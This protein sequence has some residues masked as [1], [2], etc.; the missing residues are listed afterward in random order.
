M[1]GVQKLSWND[2][3]AQQAK[4]WALQLAEDGASAELS[5]VDS[6]GEVIYVAKGTSECQS[7][8]SAILEW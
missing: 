8:R 5:G 6:L 2:Q 1:H 4:D 3:L 7:M